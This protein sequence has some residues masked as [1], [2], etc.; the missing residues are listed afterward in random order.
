MLC[1]KLFF[2][3]SLAAG[4]ALASVAL[5]VLGERRV[6][7]GEYPDARMMVIATVPDPATPGAVRTDPV[8]LMSLP[9]YMERHPGCTLLPSYETGE[10]EN[11]IAETTT[12]YT[13]HP[14]GEGSS[15][16][17][18]VLR[19]GLVRVRARYLATRTE[20]KPI[21]T[22]SGYPFGALLVGL[23]FASMLAIAGKALALA[24]KRKESLGG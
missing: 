23:G 15:M 16:V 1:S 20:V 21:V 9:A 11:P 18:T 6:E 22:N 7:R 13:A 3:A 24:V 19:N 17:E 2:A 10:I 5:D 4:S 12:T 8:M 14:A